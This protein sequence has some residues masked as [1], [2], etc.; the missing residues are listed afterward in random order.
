MGKINEFFWVIMKG[1][2]SV[3]MIIY[4]FHRL[5]M[6][7][8]EK[9]KK[10]WSNLK[11][12]YVQS[13][14]FSIFIGFIIISLI[15]KCLHI[16]YLKKVCNVNIENDIYVVILMTYI[17]I[18]SIVIFF[19]YSWVQ[20]KLEIFNS[21]C[22]RVYGIDNSKND[23]YVEKTKKEEKKYLI[24]AMAM[25][26]KDGELLLNIKNNKWFDTKQSRNFSISREILSVKNNL[27]R[28]KNIEGFL[29]IRNNTIRLIE[30]TIISLVSFFLLESRKI[31]FEIIK[32]MPNIVE[33]IRSREHTKFNISEQTGLMLSLI[34]LY[35]AFISLVSG[36]KNEKNRM[37]EILKELSDESDENLFYKI[38]QILNDKKNV[39]TQIK[40][41]NAKI[42][43]IK[44][45]DGLF[46]SFVF[47]LSCSGLMIWLIHKILNLQ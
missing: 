24:I 20:R 27:I 46:F 42:G 37:V 29:Y 11:I 28:L 8:K 41:I 22:V 40:E 39:N 9:L 23:N 18:I 3:F 44:F 21:F 2:A 12:D 14:L 6:F 13:L 47:L 19:I 17:L 26:A 5:F 25:C 30:L 1:L 31:I 10:W 45:K 36:M 34:A 32:N 7:F 33:I 43:E 4:I 16:Y 15:I 35:F 38:K